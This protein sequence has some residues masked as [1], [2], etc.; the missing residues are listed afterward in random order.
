M[1]QSDEQQMLCVSF[2]SRNQLAANA[3]SLRQP[4][5]SPLSAVDVGTVPAPVA[6]VGISPAR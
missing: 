2:S 1:L 5:S 4:S 6:E 3:M